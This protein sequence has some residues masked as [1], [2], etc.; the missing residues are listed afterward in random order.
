[1]SMCAASFC[2]TTTLTTCMPSCSAA[3]KVSAATAAADRA[4]RNYLLVVR[5]TPDFTQPFGINL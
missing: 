3:E 1:M 4:W 2:T 5:R